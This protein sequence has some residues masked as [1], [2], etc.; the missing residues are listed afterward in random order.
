M[1]SSASTPRDRLTPDFWESRYQEGT[2]RWDLGQAAPP[3]VNYFTQADAPRPGKAIVLGCGRGYDAVFLAQQGF[4]VV[5]VDFAPAAIAAS[6]QLAAETG[7]HAQF[8]QRDIFDLVPEYA[9]Q[10]DYVIEHTCFCALAPDLRDRY[11]SLVYQ[12]LKPQGQYIGLFFTHDR[13]GGPPFGVQPA[14]IRDLFRPQFDIM[15]LTATP[16][17]VPSRLGEE[18]LG[19]FQKPPSS[20]SKVEAGA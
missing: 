11:V 2:P 1:T 18:H 15:A 5:G 3:L 20:E 19:R 10:F 7:V 13:P 17:S 14:T 9:Q 6:T 8:I 4:A 16:H 12:L